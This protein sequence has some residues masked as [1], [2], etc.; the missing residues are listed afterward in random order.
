MVGFF[1]RSVG[2]KAGGWSIVTISRFTQ[3]VRRREENYYISC[4]I[5]EKV[6]SVINSTY[7]RWASTQL[8][9]LNLLSKHD[10]ANC[11]SRSWVF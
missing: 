6:S 3:M 7:H 5:K 10:F 1:P 9:L 2:M 8:R 4:L 11:V